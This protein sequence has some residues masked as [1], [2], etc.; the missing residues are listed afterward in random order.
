MLN[1]LFLYKHEGTDDTHMDQF[2]LNVTDGKFVESRTFVVKIGL[3]NSETPRL[4]VNTGLY[5]KPGE[6]T[7]I[8]NTDLKA[9]DIDSEDSLLTY[10]LTELPSSGK[11]QLRQGETFVDLMTDDNLL[12]RFLQQ[13]I[14][15][16]T[17]VSKLQ[18]KMLE[19]CQVL[20][21]HL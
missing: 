5:I 9:T 2:T 8:K 17:V 12:N 19:D 18:M 10:V 20:A 16:G 3:T 4:Q 13:D 6:T 15:G 11:L 1:E 21:V 7:L 14:D